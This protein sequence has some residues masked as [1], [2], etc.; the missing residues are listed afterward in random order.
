MDATQSVAVYSNRWL[1]LALLFACRTGLG[2]QFQTLGSVS[3]SLV[4]QLGFS[5]AEIGTLIGLFMLPGL[6][7]ALPA[8][9]VGR[10]LPDRTLVAVGLLALGLAAAIASVAQ[11]F[12]LLALGR[13][14][15]GA[16][17]VISTIYLTK[18]VAD[19]FAGK[20]LATAMGILVM[21]W[22]FGIAMGQIGHVWIAA[23]FD[24]RAAFLVAAVYCAVGAV[25][26]F[27]LYRPPVR[28]QAGAGSRP[29]RAA[30]L[31]AGADPAG[32][33]GVGPVQRRLH[34]LPE[35]RPARVDGRRLRREH[36]RRP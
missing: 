5:Y 6:V 1:I 27:L 9:Y 30:A 34:R 18:M 25:A 19:W 36:R 24:W 15:A 7:L 2:F 35:L 31:R 23:N 17:F 4:A 3:D 12:G 21:S 11:G 14:A 20:E 10:Y 26:V 32:R 16:G 29:D 22:P 28:C 8:G 33:H 13:V